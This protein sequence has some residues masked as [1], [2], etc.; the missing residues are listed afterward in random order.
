MAKHRKASGKTA[1][2][3]RHAKRLKKVEQAR[4]RLEK[5]RRKLWALEDKLAE[6]VYSDDGSA[7]AQAPQRR[8]FLI[9]NPRAKG[10]KNGT[11]RLEQI[12]ACMRSHGF[13]VEVGLKNSGHAVRMMTRGAVKRGADLIVVAAGDGTIEDVAGELVGTSAALGLIPVG[14]MNN[15]ARCLGVPL[16][17]EQSCALLAIGARRNIDVGRVVRQDK[18]HR[19][20]FLETAGV[21]LSAL[22]APIGQA[23]EKGRLGLLLKTLGKALTFKGAHLTVTCDDRAPIELHTEVVTV[24]NAPLFGKHML[25]GP[26]AKMDDG[27]LDVA[28]YEG[29][30]KLDLERHLLAISDGKR[31]DDPR[32][33]LQRAQ[34][35]RIVADEPLAANADMEV[36]AEQRIWEI[37]VLPS[38]LTVI[39]GNGMALT[40]PVAAARVAPP[41]SGPQPPA[42]PAA[43]AEDPAAQPAA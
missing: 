28:L 43:P 5:A 29:M 17:L 13:D 2:A 42:P 16:D 30:S 32:V 24:S 36:L 10:V 22:A 27:L 8:A 38:A 6:R 23:T 21:G 7:P 41:I 20:Y 18:P 4:V 34:R 9:F 39:A 37:E 15:L 3:R 1:Q 31:V 19:G 26:D 40:L 11:Y 14:T 33:S 35:V 25:I 12:V